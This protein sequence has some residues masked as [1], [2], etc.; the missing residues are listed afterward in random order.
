MSTRVVNTGDSNYRTPGTCDQTGN[1]S[2][3]YPWRWTEVGR[4]GKIVALCS[5]YHLGFTDS[6]MAACHNIPPAQDVFLLF[7]STMPWFGPMYDRYRQR[8]A[9]EKHNT[10]VL[11]PFNAGDVDNRLRYCFAKP[12]SRKHT[13]TPRLYGI[14]N[15]HP[16]AVEQQYWMRITWVKCSDEVCRRLRLGLPIERHEAYEWGILE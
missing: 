2:I 3:R 13:K 10:E 4:V 9:I 16:I 12:G 7:D 8:K 6:D 11:Q 5:A 14:S 15:E 1:R